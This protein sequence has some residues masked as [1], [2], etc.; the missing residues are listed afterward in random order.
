MNTMRAHGK[1]RKGVTNT[2]LRIK[3]GQVKLE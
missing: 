3:S 1:E 2:R